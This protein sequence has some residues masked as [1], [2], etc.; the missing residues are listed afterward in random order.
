MFDFEKFETFI[1]TEQDFLLVC[2]ILIFIIL[3][4][5]HSVKWTDGTEYAHCNQ[6]GP[7]EQH[8]GTVHGR[9]RFYTLQTHRPCFLTFVP[10]AMSVSN[11]CLRMGC[12]FLCLLNPAGASCFCPEGTTLINR[13]CRDTNSSGTVGHQ[14]VGYS[15][16]TCQP[17]SYSMSRDSQY[18]RLQGH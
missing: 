16:P 18:S 12:D 17:A 4:A 5:L 3:S 10:L 6:P 2:V 7:L 13:T 8:S 1:M 11:P 14:C 15:T 9:L